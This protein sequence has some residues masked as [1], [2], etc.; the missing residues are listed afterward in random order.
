MHPIRQE[1]PSSNSLTI[2]GIANSVELFKGEI[3]QDGKLKG[4]AHE[5][6]HHDSFMLQ[7]SSLICNN[8]AKVLFKP[9]TKDSLSEILQRLYETFLLKL[10]VKDNPDNILSKQ[11]LIHPKA[12]QLAAGRID[13]VSGDIRVCFEILRQAVQ[14]KAEEI[15]ERQKES[16]GDQMELSKIKV[17][18]LFINQV[19]LDMFES[20]LLKLVRKLPRAHIIMLQQLS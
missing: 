18:Q 8:E 4:L 19:I 6:G 17:S 7:K 20:K 5:E 9:Y 10:S 15:R 3:S 14:N 11:E 13:K 2:I 1:S 12:F 16:K